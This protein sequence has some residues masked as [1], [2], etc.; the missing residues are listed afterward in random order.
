MGNHNCI[1]VDIEFK[2]YN[3]DIEKVDAIG[4]VQIVLVKGDKGDIYMPTHEELV[5]IIDDYI[6]EH[7]EVLTAITFTDAN[8]DGNIVITVGGSTT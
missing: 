5:D 8:N 4:E 3:I 7:P 2:N 6:D 1:D